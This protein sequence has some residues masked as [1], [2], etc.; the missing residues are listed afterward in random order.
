MKQNTHLLDRILRVLLGAILIALV[1]FGSNKPW[2]WLGLIPLV[3]GAIGWC[4]I[5]TLLGIGTWRPRVF[6]PATTTKEF[7]QPKK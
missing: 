2:Y 1:L 6:S 7:T 5:Y 3:T 4:P